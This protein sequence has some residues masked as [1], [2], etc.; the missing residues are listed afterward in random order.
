MKKGLI[1]PHTRTVWV[2]P[3]EERHWFVRTVF[4]HGGTLCLR[5]P[6][7]LEK[8][9]GINR[10]TYLKLWAEKGKIIIEEVKPSAEQRESEEQ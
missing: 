10:G 6:K 2:R 9:L 1:D 3:G 4:S 7:P 5:I 8:K